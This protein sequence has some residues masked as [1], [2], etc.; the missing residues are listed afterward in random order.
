[1][2]QIQVDI[3]PRKLRFY[4]L[5]PGDVANAIGDQNL[6]IPAGTEKVGEIEYNVELNASPL[7]PEKI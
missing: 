1:M 2:R 5:S 7:K 6:I 4:G 3:D